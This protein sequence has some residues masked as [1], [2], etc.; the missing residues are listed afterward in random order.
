MG[1]FPKECRYS[2]VSKYIYNS[3]VINEHDM[4]H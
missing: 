2:I 1:D 4:D 3:W